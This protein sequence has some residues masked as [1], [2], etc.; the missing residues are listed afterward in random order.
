MAFHGV[1]DAPRVD[2]EIVGV[3]TVSNLSYGSSS[4]APVT[5]ASGVDRR[6]NINVGSST[7][8]S[9]KLSQTQARDQVGAIIFASG[10]LDPAN[11]PVNNNN[12]N[13]PAFGLYIVYPTGEV[14]PLSLVSGINRGPIGEVRVSTWPTMAGSWTVAVSAGASSK[15]PYRLVSTTGQVL[16]E[17][18]WEVPGAG[19]WVYTVPADAYSAGVY[20]LQV[21]E[22]TY[23][24]L[25]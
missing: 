1:T 18:T 9:F 3:G 22:S 2:V 19:S 6:I 5:F 11:N 21:G 14:E 17:G 13:S 23:R 25:K 15:L 8:A 20:L 7:V 12:Q 4:A 24:L 16:Q 10:F